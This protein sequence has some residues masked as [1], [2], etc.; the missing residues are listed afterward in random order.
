MNQ[1]LHQQYADLRAFR[2]SIFSATTKRQDAAMNLIDALLERPKPRSLAELSLSPFCERQWCSLYDVVEEASFDVSSLERTYCQFSVQDW[3]EHGREQAKKYGFSTPC[4]VVVGDASMIRRSSSRVVDGL[5]YCHTQSHEVGGR[6][7]VVGHQYQLLRYVGDAYTA[8]SLPLMSTR[9]EEHDTAVSLAV[10]QMKHLPKHLPSDI[11][12]LGVFDG[13]Y[14]C[15]SFLA[16]TR[17]HRC[18]VLARMRFDRTLFHAPSPE[19]IKMRG[20]P[21]VYGEAFDRERAPNESMPDDCCQFSDPYFGCVLLQRWNGLLIK[22]PAND[23]KHKHRRQEPIV[24]DIMRCTVRCQTEKPSTIWLIFQ[25]NALPP[26]IAENTI[27]LW[28][29]FDARV[30]IEASIKVSK[31]ECSWTMPQTL[32]AQ[33]ADRW[34]HLTN[35]TFWHLF[36]ARRIPDIVHYK[37]QKAD[38]PIT[39]RRVRQSMAAILMAVGSPAKPPLQRGKSPGWQPGKSRT[40]KS[41]ISV[42]YKGSSTSKKAAT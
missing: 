24:V 6:G 37:W 27:A 35:I 30:G 10:H 13:G 40:K 2:Q 19:T 18:G 9:L 14:G 3:R 28:S 29:A 21:R 25:A 15:A 17:Q 4:F 23:A 22:P 36:L 42:I 31:Q 1:S 16:E 11:P 33:A 26:S 8:W 12:C 39:P 5:R 32:T 38:A 20:A 7:I 34:T 41:P